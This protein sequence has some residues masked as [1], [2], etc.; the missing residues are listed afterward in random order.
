MI[1]VPENGPCLSG[2]HGSILGEHPADPGALTRAEDSPTCRH[3]ALWEVE[4]IS[5]VPF[6]DH[7]EVLHL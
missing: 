5:F 1:P 6:T 4:S 3:L 7:G 2:G